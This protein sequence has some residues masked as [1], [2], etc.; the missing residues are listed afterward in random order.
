MK[1]IEIEGLGKM[2]RTGQLVSYKTVQDSLS[3]MFRKRDKAG[4]IWALKDISLSVEQGEVLGIIGANGAGKSTLLKILSKITYP[5]EGKAIIRGKSSA[6]LEVGAGFH[7]EFTGR[8]NIYLNG[9]LLGMGKGEIAKKLESIVSFSGIGD[10]LDTPVKRYSSGMFVR[11][12]FAVAAHLEPEILIIDEVLSVGD[13]QF[14]KKSLAKMESSAKE[15]RTVLFVSHN[16]AAVKALCSRCILLDKGRIVEVGS[17]NEVVSHYLSES[18]QEAFPKTVE[19]NMG[20]DLLKINAVS[21]ITTE[22][23]ARIGLSQPIIIEIAYEVIRYS[24][25]KLNIVLFDQGENCLFGSMS[26]HDRPLPVGKYISTCIIPSNWL[27]EGRFRISV[28][29]FGAQWTEPFRIHKAL[30][31]QTYDDGFTKDYF[32]EYSGPFR[33][34]L[35]WN[36]ERG[37]N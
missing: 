9:T 3:S 17:P 2:Y 23:T 32:R 6:L 21:L 33:P 4:F 10:Y 27:N 19:A 35:K 25:I 34:Q 26:N 12:A 37:N 5:T 20:N 24:Q 18:G 7:P 8:E 1:S 13:A 14:Q 28:A 22:P 31:F 16:L 30:V 29:G 11:L 36:T 15:G